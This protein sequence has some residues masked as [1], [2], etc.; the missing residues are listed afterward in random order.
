M[1]EAK[2]SPRVVRVAVP[3]PLRQTFDY[4]VN[5]VVAMPAAGTRVLVPVRQR[6]LVAVV[7]ASAVES[8]VRPGSLRAVT[9]VIDDEPAIPSTLLSTLSWAST[10]YHHPLGEVIQAA[11]PSALRRP[12]ALVPDLPNAYRLTMAGR[13][14]QASVPKRA[15]LQREL[16]ARLEDGSALQESDLRRDLPGAGA[17]LRRL[18]AHGW[19]KAELAY[20]Q[21]HSVSQSSIT[22]SSAQHAAVTELAATVGRFAPFLLHGV[23]GSGKTEV[24]LRAAA[25]TV[26]RNKQVLIL[27][28]EIALTPQFIARIQAVVGGRLVVFHSQ[29]P[30][31]ERHRA[32]WASRAGLADVVLGTRSA[33]FTPFRAL[34]LVIVDEEHDLSYKQQEGFRYHARDIAVKRA[35]Q[36]RVPVV[37]GTATPALES[38]ANARAGRYQLLRLPERARSA[39][40][41]RV[42]LL[43][44]SALSTTEGLSAPVIQ[45]LSKRL[46]SD[47]Q[48][49]V[50]VNRRGF[51]PV[52]GCG[53]CGWQGRCQ[54][55]DAALTL[56]R[57]SSALRCHHC[58]AS[59]TAHD[60]CPQ[61][62]GV[63]LY[64]VG[65]G[66]QRVEE[67]LQRLFPSARVLRFD[68]DRVS[69][70]AQLV[71]DLERVRKGDI[72]ILVGTQLLSKGH[73]FP[74][75]TLVC[76]LSADR[77][78]YATDFRSGER[79]FQQLMQ[80]SGRAGRA[81]LPG[82]VLIQT[83]YPSAPAYRHLIGQDFDGF[84]NVALDERELAGCPPYRRFVLLRAESPHSEAPQNFLQ[85]AREA[86]EQCLHRAPR[87]GVVIMDVVPSPME[88]RAG[89]YRAQLLVSAHQRSGL[90][91]FLTDWLVVLDN[92]RWARQV[93]WSIDV[94]PQEMY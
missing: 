77:G 63:D 82:E 84:A 14:A 20:P 61:C 35:Q 64:H 12:R 68:S 1:S 57:R 26:G 88:R 75:V 54:R 59:D 44:L 47:E 48:S 76:V 3:L 29:M 55:C 40:M 62:K 23:T 67:A 78:L 21:A 52:V 74:A 34:G 5:A 65:E 73:D 9:Q 2:S 13:A 70:G 50:Y 41:P 72:D 51:A 8:S 53:A 87:A 38:I 39:Q 37:L 79:L 43:D 16:L 94:D 80:V 46:A 33:V 27:V 66:T 15:R 24:Y 25:E 71:T 45:A 36:A 81:Q 6:T 17:A 60:H 86:G 93:R 83:L 91:A 22:L 85:R 42:R 56:H 7:V 31:G 18:E 19:I 89:R 69:A 49:I 28:P 11:L 30:D 10:Y 58:G 90:H 4:R 32:W 92:E